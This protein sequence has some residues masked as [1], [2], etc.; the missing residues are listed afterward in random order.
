MPLARILT[1]H[2]DDAT[3]LI[4]QL[5]R[6]GFAVE[7]ASP[8]QENLDPAELEIEFAV[9]DQQQVI[10][11]AGAIAN[12]LQAEIVVFP[13]AIPPVP[14]PLGVSEQNAVSV[15][16][17]EETPEEET[18]ETAPSPEL[19]PQFEAE[20]SHSS[21]PQLA[22]VWLDGLTEKVRQSGRRTA[23]GLKLVQAGIS[24][25]LVRVGSRA[26]EYGERMKTRAVELRAAREQR[27]IEAGLRRAEAA[28][29]AALLEQEERRQAEIALA[30]QQ[31]EEAQLRAENEKRAQ[32][33][34]PVVI[35]QQS[36]A[37]I[38]TPQF[39]V[40]N[41]QERRTSVRTS[42]LRGVFTGAVAA[43][44]LFAVGM[45]LANFTPSDPFPSSVSNGSV[46][47][48][49]P[50]GPTTLHGPPGA[51]VG[52]PTASN[53]VHPGNS[54]PRQAA[55]AQ[56]RLQ[57]ASTKAPAKWRHFRRSASRGDD[58]GAADDVVV[59]HFGPQPRPQP[60]AQQAG[61]KHY[62][63]MP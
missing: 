11:R 46:D 37:E 58:G 52:G 56:S 34:E 55:P 7:V 53:A 19:V 24:S 43:S 23:S 12:Q 44:I 1:L 41:K 63:D 60:H 31:Q 54:V 20:D 42:Q 61:L 6:L 35:Q 36:P 62:S 14:K 26:A 48:Q 2:P 50:F 3:I 18:V 21:L 10:A 28:R 59:R 13:G 22:G 40:M 51:T 32:A 9:C 29:Q 4:Q 17:Q 57:P 39:A 30:A 15:P 45:V 27:R 8:N 5:E 38:E 47:Q 25:T 49:M 16:N 33:T